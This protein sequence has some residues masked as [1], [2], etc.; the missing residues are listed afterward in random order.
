MNIIAHR[1]AS[2][3]A[4]ENTLAAFQLGWERN[5]DGIEGDFQL[6]K[7]G[8][9]VCMHDESTRRTYGVDLS[10]ADETYETLRSLDAGA[11]KSEEYAGEHIPLIEEIIERVPRDKLFYIE[12][13]CGREILVPL[14]TVLQASDLTPEQVVIISFNSGAV[15]EARRVLAGSK[16]YWITSFKRVV[17]TGKRVPTIDAILEVLDE[18]NADG[19]DCQGSKHINEEF[20]SRLRSAGKEFHVWTIDTVKQSKHFMKLG[21]DSITTNRPGKVKE[22]VM[23][24]RGNGGV[25]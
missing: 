11:W 14:K 7:D 22:G 19:L 23:E 9:I 8:R 10:I 17:P 5:A 4:P 2:Y 6:T 3:D 1:G 12:I 25:T 20:V 18:C 13:K 21:V 15:K 24:W 16:A